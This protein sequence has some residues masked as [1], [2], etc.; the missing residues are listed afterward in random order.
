MLSKDLLQIIKDKLEVDS[1]LEFQKASVKID[2]ID[3]MAMA[4]IEYFVEGKTYLFDVLSVFKGI[5][6]DVSIGA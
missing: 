2:V 6:E 4:K 3:G 5:S 1:A